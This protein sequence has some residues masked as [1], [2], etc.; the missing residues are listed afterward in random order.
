MPC[1]S[2]TSRVTPQA[3][4]R[5]RD[6]QEQG[7]VKRAE[8]HG[9]DAV[10]RHRAEAKAAYEPQQRQQGRKQYHPQAKPVK[11]I[12]RFIRT[13]QPEA[14]KPRASNRDST[15]VAESAATATERFPASACQPIP[16]SRTGRI[17]IDK[18]CRKAKNNAANK[19][20]LPNA[21]ERDRKSRAAENCAAA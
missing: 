12:P 17:A 4:L 16:D 10:R 5:Q 8:L 6:R 2:L 19:T 20:N 21:R 11:E 14:P 15:A 13:A 18:T 7:R 1:E 9:R 3:F